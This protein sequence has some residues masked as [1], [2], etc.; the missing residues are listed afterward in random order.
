MYFVK[1]EDSELGFL[2]FSLLFP[3]LFILL[4]LFSLLELNQEVGM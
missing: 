3:V 4:F 2:H 1:V